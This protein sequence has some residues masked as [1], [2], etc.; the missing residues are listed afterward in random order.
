MGLCSLEAFGG[1]SGSVLT[2]FPA[3]ALGCFPG[4]CG[5]GAV[6]RSSPGCWGFLGSS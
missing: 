2:G 3:A 5:P 4:G 1:L 6:S